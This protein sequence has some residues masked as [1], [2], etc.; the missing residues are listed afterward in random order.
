MDDSI[1]SLPFLRPGVLVQCS[2][3]GEKAADVYAADEEAA[4]AGQGV[5]G[6][7]AALVA[8]EPS[9]EAPSPVEEADSPGE[10]EAG[11]QAASRRPRRKPPAKR[12]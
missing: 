3:C 4:L 11:E 8:P 12:S 5:C 2:N 1:L 6:K 7:C 9:T 10:A